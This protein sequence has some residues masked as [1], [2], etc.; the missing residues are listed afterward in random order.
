MITIKTKDEIALMRE[1]GRIAADILR[2]V[3]KKVA[4]GVSTLELNELA[5]ELILIANR[6]KAEKQTSADLSAEAR[7]VGGSIR[8]GEGGLPL[9]KSAFLGQISGKNGEPFPAV[10][11]TSLNS[12][13]VHGVPSDYKLQEGDIL[14]LDFGVVY[15]GYYSDLAVTVPVGEISDEAR[16][17]IWITKKA[18]KRGI[19]K[20]RPGNT[21]GDIGNTIE[22][23]VESQGYQVVRTLVGHGVGKSLHEEPEVPNYGKRRGGAELSEGMVI[24]IEPMVAAGSYD[25]KFA[26][27]RYGF[28]TKSGAL[29]AHFEHTVAVTAKAHRILT[30]V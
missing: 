10:L 6:N 2:K 11:T 21:T 12:V 9:V 27:D 3:Q 29:S 8:K 5:R 28:E 1:S 16:R 30:E 19:K 4:P 17:L 20:V 13:V 22:R 23:Y 15:K 26:R 7:G 14:G 18:L 24:A 25:V